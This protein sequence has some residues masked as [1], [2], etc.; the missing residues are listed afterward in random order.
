MTTDD[1][2]PSRFVF[3]CT[4]P[5]LVALLVVLP[6]AASPPEPTGWIGVVAVELCA[7]LLLLGLFDNRRFWWCLR[8]VGAFVFL[9]Y[10]IYMLVTAFSGQWFGNGRKSSV[11]AFN[12][13]LGL[14][15]FGLPGLWYACF[16]RLTLRPD[17]D[18]ENVYDDLEDGEEC[19]GG[20]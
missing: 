17:P 7:A 10:V 16:G 18:D 13:V 8:G 15:F 6:L 3:Y 4:A 19:D 11:S 1:L 20:G 9:A 5:L 12:A 14:I 2:P